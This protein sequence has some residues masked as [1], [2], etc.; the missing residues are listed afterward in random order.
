MRRIE[1]GQGVRQKG[2]ERDRER[3]GKGIQRKGRNINMRRNRRYR[4]KLIKKCM[5]KRNR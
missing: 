5:G 4:Y 3:T 1:M 2:S